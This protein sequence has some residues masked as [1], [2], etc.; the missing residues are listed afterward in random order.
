[1]KYRENGQHIRRILNDLSEMSSDTSACFSA[2][3]TSGENLL[4]W[5]ATIFGPE[6][7]P[8]EGGS[9]EFDITFPQDY[10]FSPPK[11]RVCTKIFHCNIKD[12]SICLDIIGKQ[13]SSALTIS[14]VLL[15]ITSL[16]AD[17][18]P[19]DPLDPAISKLYLQDVSEYMRIA[20]EWTQKYAML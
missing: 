17:P 5:K 15:S 1:M 12:N 10:P 9:F 6:G 18:N 19:L 11:I 13:W 20:R 2:G 4:V 3:P 7:T 14:K 8:Y 16:L